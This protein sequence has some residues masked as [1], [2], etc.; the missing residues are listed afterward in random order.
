MA[1]TWDDARELDGPCSVW[2]GP[3]ERGQ[4]LVFITPRV[5]APVPARPGDYRGTP[6]ARRHRGLRPIRTAAV[7]AGLALAA[8]PG[9][10]CHSFRPA[11]APEPGA[12][13]RVRYPA[14]RTL[15]A[16][17]RGGDTTGLAAIAAVE[18]RVRAA[19]GDTLHLA[20]HSAR[21]ADG[22]LVLPRQSAVAL[23]IAPTAGGTVEASRFDGR[24]T[25]LVLALSAAAVA[26]LGFAIFLITFSQLGPNY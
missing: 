19:R 1:A 11:S 23:A 10:A 4:S 22:R 6:A 14:P 13:V 12:T 18:G 25:A 16:V 24:K 17:T 8:A 2:E 5:R 26:A 9:V 15:V 20:F 3:L 21:T 7:V